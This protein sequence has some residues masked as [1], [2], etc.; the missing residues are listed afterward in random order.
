MKVE[1]LPIPGAWTFTPRLHHDDRGTFLEWYKADLVEKAVGRALPLVQ[2]NH[3]ISK[4]GVVRGVHFAD[5]PPGQAKYVYCPRGA[6]LDYVVDVRVGSP[7]FGRYEA[8][9]L[10]ESDRRAVYIA[11]GL[12]HA[13]VALTDDAAVT[14]LCSTG[15]DPRAEHT[16]NPLDPAIGIDWGLAQPL[17]SERD[18]AAPALAEAAETGLLPEY[19]DCVAYYES[20]TRS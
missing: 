15:Y 6:V 12:G 19:D 13:F 5:A 3:S 17:L 18:A 2:A 20:L 14:Y 11:E 7:T 16:V 9:R 4:R 10:D 1:E 8:V